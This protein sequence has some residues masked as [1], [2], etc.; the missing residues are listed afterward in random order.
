ME[1]TGTMNSTITP[2]QCRAAR[3]LIELTQAELAEAADVSVEALRDFEAGRGQQNRSQI[4]A[5]RTAIESAGLEFTGEGVRR[6]LPPLAAE[7]SSDHVEA[8]PRLAAWPGR[9]GGEGAPAVDNPQ[10]AAS[11]RGR[12]DRMAKP[13]PL[14]PDFISA[15]R[16]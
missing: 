2:A 12:V 14:S 3:G 1:M 11:N 10:R 7:E 9:L 16:R 15:V 13:D 5:I 8:A 4:E 6:S